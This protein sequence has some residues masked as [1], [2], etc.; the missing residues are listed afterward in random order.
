MSRKYALRW[1]AVSPMQPEP[2]RR[3]MQAAEALGDWPLAIASG[4]ALL[5]FDPIDA[6]GIHLQLATT[7]QRSGDLM[8]ARRHALLALEET[9][10]F[11]DAQKRLLEIAREIE[12]RETTDVRQKESSSASSP[13]MEV[14]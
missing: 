8:S 1:L 7:L 6:A 9:P 4:R 5:A 11:R 3:S 10:R 13:D 2:H 14:P 12:Q